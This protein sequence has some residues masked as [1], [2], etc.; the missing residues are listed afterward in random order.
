MFCNVLSIVY[1]QF[2]FLR[3]FFSCKNKHQ[4]FVSHVMVSSV[5]IVSPPHEQNKN[6]KY[7]RF[8]SIVLID[9]M[10]AQFPANIEMLLRKFATV[11]HYF[12]CSSCAQPT[13]MYMWK[14]INCIDKQQIVALTLKICISFHRIKQTNIDFVHQT[15]NEKK[16]PNTF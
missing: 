7:T 14:V 9:F 5:L 16:K 15:E 11:V 12:W 3:F 13:W 10:L 4:M 1:H 2:F 8:N 6:N